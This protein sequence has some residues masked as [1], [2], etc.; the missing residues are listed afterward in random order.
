MLRTVPL[1]TSALSIV[2]FHHE[3][4]EG[5]GYPLGLHGEGIPL[6]ARVFAVADTLDAMTVDRPYRRARSWDEAREEIVSYSGTQ[7][8][9]MVVE[10]YLE[11]FDR[12]PTLEQTGVA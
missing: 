2:R 12:L 5:G 8:D 3:R 6:G 9:P 10:A 4:Y 7:F 1:L 11:I